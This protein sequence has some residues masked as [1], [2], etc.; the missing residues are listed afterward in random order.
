VTI[1]TISPGVD[2]VSWAWFTVDA[3]PR[4]TGS[5]RVDELSAGCKD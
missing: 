2:G 3:D 1:T 5:A 4:R